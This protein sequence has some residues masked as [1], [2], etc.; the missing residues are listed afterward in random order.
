MLLKKCQRF[1]NGEG[2]IFFRV[3]GDI[4]V[5]CIRRKVT[6]KSNKKSKFLYVTCPE[7]CKI[8]KQQNYGFIKEM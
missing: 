6:Y 3:N 8:L 5:D 7:N 2:Y 1:A 4:C